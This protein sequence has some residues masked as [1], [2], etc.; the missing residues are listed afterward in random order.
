M[1]RLVL[2]CIMLV[3]LAAAIRP[4]ERAV[5]AT[6]TGH[7]VKPEKLMSDDGRVKL[8]VPAGFVVTKFAEGLGKPRVLAVAS[9]VYVTRPT[10][11]RPDSDPDISGTPHA[12]GLLP[13]RLLSESAIVEASLPRRIPHSWSFNPWWRL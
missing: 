12:G 8:S 1:N 9:T 10:L 3:G 13:L 2:C 6:I 7:V 4:Q 5:S 11:R